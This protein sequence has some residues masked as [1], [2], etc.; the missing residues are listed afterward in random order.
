M[1]TH[2]QLMN[3]YL[4]QRGV[5]PGYARQGGLF[6]V[7]A[8]EAAAMSFPYARQSRGGIVIPYFHPLTGEAHPTVRRIRFFDPLPT[9]SE[10]EEIRYIQPKGSGVEAYFDPNVDW[11]SVLTDSRI[12]I[13]ITEGEVKAQHLNQ[14]RDA[15]GVVT[16]ALGGV[17]SFRSKDGD[18][19]TPWLRALRE[20]GRA[21]QYVIAFDSDMAE[22]ES[23]QAAACTLWG[24][25]AQ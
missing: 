18:D 16:V 8:A 13:A 9:D 7:T 3:E 5:R 15:L 22:N 23:I 12:T 19:L 4:R 1:S 14:R 10:G 2:E 21:R 25:L 20:V 17:W 24:L 6:A 11:A